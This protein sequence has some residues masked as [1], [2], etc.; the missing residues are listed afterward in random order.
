MEERLLIFW[1]YVG[2]TF[3]STMWG[4]AVP[5]G[6]AGQSPAAA[7]TAIQFQK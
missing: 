6:P 2:T 3:F 1:I 4:M 7:F 5:G